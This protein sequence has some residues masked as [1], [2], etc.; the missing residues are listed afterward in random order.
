[1]AK[2]EHHNLPE[3]IRPKTDYHIGYTM[4]LAIVPTADGT[5]HI[6]KAY[7][8]ASR[9]KP[10]TIKKML[11]TGDLFMIDIGETSNKYAGTRVFQYLFERLG[12]LSFVHWEWPSKE[13]APKNADKDYDE[14][15]RKRQYGFKFIREKGPKPII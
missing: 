14:H 12:G 15:R 13:P 1:M 4:S 10:A 9:Q 11:A 7:E 5:H 2:S 6:V 8:F 3:G